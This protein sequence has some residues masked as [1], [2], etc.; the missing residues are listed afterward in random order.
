VESIEQFG[1]A[2]IRLAR[3][4]ESDADRRRDLLQEIHVAL[5][6][7]FA[8]FDERCSLRTWVYRVSHITAMK[9]ITASRRLRLNAM[10]SIEEVPEIEDERSSA[11]LADSQDSLRRLMELIEKLK[12]LDRQVVLLYLED[13]SAEEIGEVV[14]LSARNVATKIHRIKKLLTTLFHSGVRP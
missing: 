5:W 13:L 2:L 11:A 10:Y 9:H 7:S 1:S 3:G 8:A 12:P 4:Y 6:K 14:G